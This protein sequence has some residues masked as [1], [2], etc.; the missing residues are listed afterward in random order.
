MSLEAKLNQRNTDAWLQNAYH[1]H[2]IQLWTHCTAICGIDEPHSSNGH[3][4]IRHERD[5]LAHTPR[6]GARECGNA[7]FNV[8][9]RIDNNADCCKEP[10]AK[11]KQAC[12]QDGMSDQPPLKRSFARGHFW[13]I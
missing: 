10:Q 9:I 1:S 2:H 12:L 13:P 3:P 7:R 6:E 8:F 4:P 5:N 11:N